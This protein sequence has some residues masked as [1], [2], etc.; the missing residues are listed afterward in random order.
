M[1]P[2][3]VMTLLMIALP[4]N[5]IPQQCCALTINLPI[6]K[7]GSRSAGLSQPERLGIQVLSRCWSK[8]RVI[9]VEPVTQAELHNPFTQL[10]AHKQVGTT[11]PKQCPDATTPT[12]D[13]SEHSRSIV[14]V[15]YVCKGNLTMLQ[16]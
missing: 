10:E 1:L 11:L 2:F 8:H 13:N 7:V 14:L 15:M 12:D 3:M 5:L 6:W 9:T 4:C 16:A